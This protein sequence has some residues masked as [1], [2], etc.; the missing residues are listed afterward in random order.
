VV[1]RTHQVVVS[2]GTRFALTGKLDRCQATG[3]S[4]TAAAV[5]RK[6]ALALWIT[7]GFDWVAQTHLRRLQG[8]PSE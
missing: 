7:K 6:P 1:D 5:G 3:R 2:L 4:T 8:G